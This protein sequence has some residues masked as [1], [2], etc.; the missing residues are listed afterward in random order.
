MSDVEFEPYDD[1]NLKRIGNG[2]DADEQQVEKRPF[3]KNTFKPRNFTTLIVLI[4]ASSG[5][6]SFLYYQ[7]RTHYPEQTKSEILEIRSA[8]YLYKESF[9]TYPNQLT[10]LTKSRPLRESWITDSWGNPYRYEVDN[11]EQSFI[12]QSAGS[13]GKF[14]TDDDIQ[15]K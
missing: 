8:L 15:V 6:F 14:G 5:I 2:K 3:N 4:I 1:S 7:S 11:S 13:D 10:E 12:V 9:G